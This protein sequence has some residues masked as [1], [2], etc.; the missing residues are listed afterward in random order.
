M[1]TIRETKAKPIPRPDDLTRPFWDAAKA[2]RLELQ[3]CGDC[4]YFNH[5]PRPLC[6]QCSSENLAFEQVSGRGTVYSFTLMHQFNVPGFEAEI[7]YLNVIVQLV[8]QPKLFMITNLRGPHADEV[9]IGQ[10]V[11]VVFEQV[12]DDISLPQFRLAK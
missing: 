10:P 9:Q 5:P 8:E 4:G 2:G 3:K 12:N 7:P 6:D 1:T 11:E